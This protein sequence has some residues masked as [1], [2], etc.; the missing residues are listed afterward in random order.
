[1]QTRR[2]AIVNFSAAANDSP[3]PDKT[4]MA[5]DDVRLLALIAQGDRPA[6]AAL[7]RRHADRF[8]R[9]A[10][11]FC[12]NRQD[13]EDMVQAAFIKLW[14]KPTMWHPGRNSAFTTWF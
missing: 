8:Y 10:Y 12:N 1:M 6:F 3:E 9:V 7:V 11:R 5:E 2:R 13:A 4:G 14:E